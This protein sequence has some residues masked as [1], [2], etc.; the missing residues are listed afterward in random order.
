MTSSE[1]FSEIP[2]V[3]ACGCGK[4]LV[5]VAKHPTWGGRDKKQRYLKYHFQQQ[6]FKNVEN[7]GSRGKPWAGQLA[8]RRDVP[9]AP[10]QA[11]LKRRGYTTRS[12]AKAL[13]VSPRWGWGLLSQA[14]KFRP[15][16]AERLLRLAAGMPHS[17]TKTQIKLA[18]REDWRSKKR[19]EREGIYSRV[20]TMTEKEE[21]AA[22]QHL[23]DR[24]RM[25]I[26]I[27][28]VADANKR[29]QNG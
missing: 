27:K 15:E 6:A 29:G 8:H 26:H 4:P 25:R 5:S 1:N 17:P 20:R 3:C 23:A 19:M 2:R 12:L 14:T 16:T 9:A 28:A 13:G 24:N 21:L 7:C 22:T 11:V 18:D 10:V